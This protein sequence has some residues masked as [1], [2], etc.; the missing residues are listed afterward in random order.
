MLGPA[1]GM[2]LVKEVV[3]LE[4]GPALREEGLQSNRDVRVRWR[5]NWDDGIVKGETRQ[6]ES[7][8]G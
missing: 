1:K 7:L 6:L 5:T 8:P 3:V 2:R 4:K